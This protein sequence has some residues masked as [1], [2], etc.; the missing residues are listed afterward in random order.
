VQ[1]AAQV[2]VCLSSG[3]A[4]YLT[5]SFLLNECNLPWLVNDRRKQRPLQ[6]PLEGSSSWVG[7]EL[8][9]LPV[10]QG[11]LFNEPKAPGLEPN[12]GTSLKIL[13]CRFRW[14]FLFHEQRLHNWF[15]FL[16]FKM[17]SLAISYIYI[18]DFGCLHHFPI[19]FPLTLPWK[20]FLS[21]KSPPYFYVMFCVWLHECNQAGFHGMHGRPV[22]E[23]WATF[24]VSKSLSKITWSPQ[25]PLWTAAM[26]LAGSVFF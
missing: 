26:T 13:F 23:T 7:R 12:P 25:Q 19:S 10:P 14:N 18:G 1:T 17:Y 2:K 6:L 11:L 24:S 9:L 5:V 20:L 15:F 3:Y 21:E 4:A 22:N 8:K 16:S